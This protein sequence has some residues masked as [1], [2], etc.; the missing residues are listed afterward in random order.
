MN[1]ATELES[2]LAGAI[3]FFQN[4]RRKLGTLETDV[5]A[6]HDQIH[7]LSSTLVTLKQDRQTDRQTLANLNGG[8]VKLQAD[9]RLLEQQLNAV[10]TRV[11]SFQQD[12]QQ[13]RQTLSAMEDDLRAQGADWRQ[14]LETTL[15]QRLAP[16][17]KIVALEQ[18]ARANQEQFEQFATIVEAQYKRL[19]QFDITLENLDQNNRSLNQTLGALKTDFER[20][21]R[22]LSALEETAGTDE[23]ARRQLQT[24]QNR[25]DALTASSTAAEQNLQAA[26]QDIAHLKGEFE[27]QHRMQADIAQIRQE[28]Q[29]HQDRLKHLETLMSKVSADTNSTR[30]ILN[31]IQSD[32]TTQNDTL[33]E[34][35]QNWRDSLATYQDRLSSVEITL[36][37]S[38]SRPATFLTEAFS[39]STVQPESAPADAD[40]VPDS[41]QAG[42]LEN[43]RESLSAQAGMLEEFQET[44]HQQLTV[45]SATL[46]AQ[47]QDLQDAVNQIADLQQDV[48]QLQQ[49]VPAQTIDPQRLETAEQYAQEIRQDVATRLDEQQKRWTELAATVETIRA[50]SKATQETVVTMASNV[51]KWIH[52][53]QNLLAATENT[54]SERLQEIEQKLIHLQAAFE[55]LENQ[56]KPRKWFSMPASLTA[57]MLI[58]GASGLAILVQVIWTIH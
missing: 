15:T 25:L 44:T 13:I 42:T 16:V 24:Q 5:N 6:Q 14:E 7:T 52:K 41:L 56:R 36:A 2:S 53:I 54:Q 39:P 33:R 34:L 27:T 30:Q 35:D 31:V 50:D 49:P 40:A 29:K 57:I 38:G 51:V 37:G 17:D 32:L 58:V 11:A 48:R 18:T 3:D 47:Q 1:D 22:V 9:D 45:L 21:E 55:T 23:A 43:L 4:L 8:L 28:L 20:H 19:L 10:E 26:R 46:D 12:Q